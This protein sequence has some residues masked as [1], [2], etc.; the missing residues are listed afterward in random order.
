MESVKSNKILF[1]NLNQIMDKVVFMIVSI[2][3][4]VGLVGLVVVGTINTPHH[5]VKAKGGCVNGSKP[6]F[7]SKGSCFHP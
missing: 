5:I 3:V 7:N 2:A 4:V 6:F 1:D